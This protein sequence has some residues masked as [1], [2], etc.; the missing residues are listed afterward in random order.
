M[1]P[2][3]F[4]YTIIFNGGSITGKDIGYTGVRD[5]KCVKGARI[6]AFEDLGAEAI[7]ELV[8]EDMPLIVGID[9]LGNDVYD[10]ADPPVA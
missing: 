3:P 10:A 7:H 4:L 5:S 2:P 6:V 9:A 8:V 1:N